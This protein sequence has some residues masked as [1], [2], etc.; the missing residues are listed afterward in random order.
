L[1]AMGTGT[2]ALLLI[3]AWLAGALLLQPASAD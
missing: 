3:G 1:I 2:L